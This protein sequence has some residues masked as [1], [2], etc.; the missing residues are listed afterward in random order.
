MTAGPLTWLGPVLAA[1]VKLSL[2]CIHAVQGTSR[3]FS[4]LMRPPP[5][6][7][8][9]HEID[10]RLGPLFVRSHEN[11]IRLSVE[12]RNLQKRREQENTPELIK[13]TWEKQH[14]R[15]EFGVITL[16]TATSLLEK[17]LHEFASR[18]MHFESY[19]S[20]LDRLKLE[21]RWIILPKLC[22]GIVLTEDSPEI[23]ELRQLI[24]ARNVIVHP[25]VQFIR[26][27][28]NHMPSTEKELNRFHIA[29]TNARRTVDALFSILNRSG[30]APVDPACLI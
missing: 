4:I 7:F 17:V 14:A 21:T 20:H 30:Q 26:A 29:C 16:L 23:N 15:F 9:T 18:H 1:T 25:K 8:G 13:D 22:A 5:P 10:Y 12:V 2:D 24:K 28:T 6:I 27:D 3:Q 19:E 11:Y